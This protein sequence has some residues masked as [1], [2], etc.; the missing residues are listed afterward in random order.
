MHFGC[1]I[2]RPFHFTECPLDAQHLTEAL[3]AVEDLDLVLHESSIEAVEE[4]VFIPNLRGLTLNVVS[5]HVSLLSIASPPPVA[6]V[7]P[8]WS[9]SL[10]CSGSCCV[11]VPSLHRGPSMISKPALIPRQCQV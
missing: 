1:V 4:L 10:V 11:C 6:G 2:F 5:D 9:L 7:G 8:E 3:V